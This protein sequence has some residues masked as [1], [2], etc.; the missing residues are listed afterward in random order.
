G[1]FGFAVGANVEDELGP[2]DSNRHRRRLELHALFRDRAGDEAKRAGDHLDRS[3]AISAGTVDIIVDRQLG[4]LAH[5]QFRAVGKDDDERALF[6]GLDNLLHEDGVLKIDLVARGAGD[7]A[8]GDVDDVAD[9][10]DA[11]FVGTGVADGRDRR[12]AGGNLDQASAR[13]GH[14]RSTAAVETAAAAA[15]GRAAPSS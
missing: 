14:H 11:G 2:A 3:R 8:P 1:H 7:R 10:A 15:E 6:F 9:R 13:Y 4:V 5:G 12:R